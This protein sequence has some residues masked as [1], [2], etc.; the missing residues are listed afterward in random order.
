MDNLINKIADSER[1]FLQAVKKFKPSVIIALV[2]GGD[3]SMAM[4]CVANLIGKIDHVVHVDTTTGIEATTEFV[5]QNVNH[6]LI[7][8]RTNE[9]TFEEIVLKNGFPGAGQHQNMYIRLKER[10]LR[11]VQRRFQ[12]DGS[13]CRIDSTTAYK[14]N[15]PLV[16]HPDY[17]NIESLVIKKPNRKIMFISGGRKD[18]SIRR[19]GT[20][21][22]IHKE[23]NQVWVSLIANWNKSDIYQLQK[24]YNLKRSPTSIL[25]GRSGECNCGSYG[26]PEEVD[27]MKYFFP[28]DK[29]V[30]MI[31]RL[32]NE[33]KQSGHKYC[34]YGHSGNNRK[35]NSE[36]KI[37]SA[38]M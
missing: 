31:I 14:K 29:N 10:A 30:N 20:V 25:L 27:E 18:E 32:Q 19:M 2:S 24:K 16:Y 28:D 8:A 7:I 23:G 36:K 37:N 3:D 26:F 4:Y 38:L 17:P 34:T 6:D 35:F 9:E 21:K 22:E 15:V 12:Y 33:L 11:I 5:K 13:F 1:I